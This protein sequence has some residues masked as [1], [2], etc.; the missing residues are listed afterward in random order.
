M[1]QAAF[2]SN[3]PAEVP[4]QPIAGN[5][6]ELFDRALSAAL[7]YEL[8]P[9]VASQPENAAAIHAVSDY[10]RPPGKKPSSEAAFESTNAQQYYWAFRGFAVIHNLDTGGYERVDPRKT[11][12]YAQ[13]IWE[14]LNCAST[15]LATIVDGRLISRDDSHMTNWVLTG[16]S[17]LLETQSITFSK[18]GNVR[19]LEKKN[20]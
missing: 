14:N 5:P 18:T 1:S 9:G 6:G 3:I 8:S 15:T 16:V 13:A 17:K 4:P 11:I 19:I 20:S 2:E 10:L 12:E 7:L